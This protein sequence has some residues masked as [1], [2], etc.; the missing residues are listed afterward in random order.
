MN[1]T[2][3]NVWYG[4]SEMLEQEPFFEG[5]M[6][7]EKY[8]GKGYL[9]YE[10]LNPV[11][12]DEFRDELDNCVSP[13]FIEFRDVLNTGI[14]EGSV[15]LEGAPG[16]G[17]SNICQDL[18]R[19]S[20]FIGLPIL[21]ISMHINAGTTR[22]TEETINLV[23]SYRR[24]SNAAGRRIFILDNVDYGGYKGSSRTRKN[25]IEYAE[26]VLPHLVEAVDDVNLIAIGAAHDEDWR[27][28]KWT[29][30]DPAID[31][32]ARELIEAYR[33]RYDFQGYMSE[34]SVQE[35]LLHR[36]A[37]PDQAMS[38]AR[39]LGKAGLLQFFYA[40]HINPEVYAKDPSEAIA[41][42]QTGRQKRYTN[43]K[44]A[45]NTDEAEQTKA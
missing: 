32:P 4:N 30:R 6:V 38:I 7:E 9:Q 17:K 11:T 16:A 34:E 15:L 26:A 25:A 39:S 31:R 37:H 35:L 23:D 43:A 12:V 29:W 21:K 18:E 5:M 8:N 42:V 40:N 27:T 1:E 14:D 10:P 44:Q 33:S 24:L 45:R 41:R 2:I 28:A 22:H 19:C 20:R 13:R 3:N 36:E